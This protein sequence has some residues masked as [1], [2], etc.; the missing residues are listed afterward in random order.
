MKQVIL[1]LLLF[2]SCSSLIGQSLD[3]VSFG[4]DTS[5]E[6]ITWNI[7]RFPKNDQ[8]TI[9]NVIAIIEALDVDILAIQEVD[10]INSFNQVVASLSGYEGYLESEYFAG[11]AYLYKSDVIEIN[12]IYEI[13]TTSEYWSYF[14]RSPMVMDFNY[15]NE[16]FL[17]INNHLKCCGDGELDLSNSSDEETRRYYANDLLKEYIDT[18]FPDDKVILLG[19]LNDLLSDDSQNNVFQVFLNDPDNYLFADLDIASGDSANWSFP[20]WPSHLDHIL[21]TNELIDE[22]ENEESDIQTI[23]I[24]EYL[25]GGWSE[26][27]QNVSDHRP[28]ALKLVID[29]TL[30]I[31]GFAPQK[32]VFKNSPNPFRIETLFSFSPASEDATLEIY[33][34]KGQKIFSAPIIKGTSS[35]RLDA[36]KFSNGIYMAKMRSQNRVMALRKLVVIK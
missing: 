8:T 16:R 9:D 18:N 34:I 26:Y 19:D 17:V 5:L 32:T 10:D 21:I 33:T 2:L 36:G 20:S 23:N 12:D 4:T 25:S 29:E 24:D 35:F 15:K 27:D 28:V 30:A 1:K 22:F 14:P 6:I 7:E 13:Y 3:D 31:A 11:L